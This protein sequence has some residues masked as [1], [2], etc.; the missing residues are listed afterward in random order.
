MYNTFAPEVPTTDL[1]M[2]TIVENQACPKHSASKGQACGN[3]GPY[4]VI[5]NSR[6]RAAGYNHKINSDSLKMKRSP[7]KRH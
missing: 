1:F 5:C 4:R 3:L 6:A 7:K 2:T